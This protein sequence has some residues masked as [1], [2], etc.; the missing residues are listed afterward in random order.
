M[1]NLIL[2][3]SCGMNVYVIN[4]DKVFFKIDETQNR[5]T[6][7]LLKVVDDLLKSAGLNVNEIE[8]ICV[9]VGPGSFTGLRVA[10]SIAKGLAIGTNAKI[11]TLTNFDIF[12][13][14]NENLCLVLDGFSSFVYARIKKDNEIFDDCFDIEELAGRIKKDNLKVFTSTEKTQ[15]LLKK[16][17]I[18]AN[19]AQ[20]QIISAFNEKICK[21]EFTSV[22]RIFPIYL[23]A[24]Q[25]E[26]ERKK[27]M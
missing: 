3:C 6:D 7:E 19:F 9:C 16:F 18:Q 14:L 10:I 1:K 2:D 27:R 11:F 5:H 12:D 8:N 15:N 25:A 24:S 22:N 26:I 13:S 20:N 17:E 4:D 23:R 21:N